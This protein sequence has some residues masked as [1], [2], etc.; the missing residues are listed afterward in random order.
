RSVLQGGAKRQAEDLGAPRR[1][2]GSHLLDR[3]RHRGDVPV[4]PGEKRS[5]SWK[6]EL[7]QLNLEPDV[8][9]HRFGM[10]ALHL[11]ESTLAV[12]EI[13]LRVDPDPLVDH[14]ESA[15]RTG[16][17]HDLAPPE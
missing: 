4:E 14:D 15:P 17:A 6:G 3:R 7:E 11:V 5:E 1:L 9:R 13:R 12:P 10:V 2:D 8:G 16:K